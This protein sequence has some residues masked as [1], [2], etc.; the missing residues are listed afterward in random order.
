MSSADAKVARFFDRLLAPKNQGKGLP[1]LYQDY[2][3]DL[4]WDL[5]LG[6]RGKKAAGL[7]TRAGEEFNLLLGLLGTENENDIPVR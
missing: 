4:Y 5:H 3:F 2:Y 1:G 7:P 6:V